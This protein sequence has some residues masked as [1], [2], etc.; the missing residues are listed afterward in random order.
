[1]KHLILFLLCAFLSVAICQNDVQ[2]DED[3]KF[4]QEY[5]G[6]IE[7]MEQL[8]NRPYR[9]DEKISIDIEKDNTVEKL[10]ALIGKNEK[11]ESVIIGIKVDK[12]VPTNRIHSLT[13]ECE[14]DT[15]FS[16]IYVLLL[17]SEIEGE[18]TDMIVNDYKFI[19]DVVIKQNFNKVQNERVKR[20]FQYQSS[21]AWKPVPVTDTTGEDMETEYLFYE[22][23]D[24]NENNYTQP[25][26]E[27]N[28]TDPCDENYY[29]DPYDG[30]LKIY[31]Q[32]LKK[33][34]SSL[35]YSLENNVQ[36][37]QIV[38]HLK[39]NYRVFGIAVYYFNTKDNMS[40]L[41]NIAIQYSK[42]IGQSESLDI[43]ILTPIL[44]KTSLLTSDWNNSYIFESVLINMSLI[45]DLEYCYSY[46]F[47]SGE[48]LRY[49][50]PTPV[51]DASEDEIEE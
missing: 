17:S 27:S 31:H 36:L 28:Y 16:N 48:N 46:S 41:Q 30:K 23:F 51:P 11:I 40:Q 6:E 24:L 25:C 13:V 12:N 10:I 1:M 15:S 14:G 22:R 32:C 8:K 9:F 20:V 44:I 4:R 34:D 7:I 21:K 3:F 45:E 49:G 33:I 2:L 19:D 39:L 35:Y 37:E 5:M 29:K 26:D 43:Y 18:N 38:E 50:F 42:E 47:G